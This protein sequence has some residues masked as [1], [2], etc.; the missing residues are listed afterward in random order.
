M[1]VVA[2]SA[3]APAK[4]EHN[5][6]GPLEGALVESMKGCKG[7]GPLVADVCKLYPKPDCSGFDAFARVLSGT[8]RVGDRVRVTKEGS[9]TGNEGTVEDLNWA[10][11]G[12]VKVQ[13]LTGESAT[14]TKSYLPS[15]LQWLGKSAFSKFLYISKPELWSVLMKAD[16]DPNDARK[17]IAERLEPVFI[18]TPPT[19][20]VACT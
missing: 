13:M 14:E 4:V 8:I 16:I 2:R 19:A 6:T 1:A 10:N 11:T 15:E 12:R 3:G 17:F 9:Q 5:Y 20:A 7:E 18:A